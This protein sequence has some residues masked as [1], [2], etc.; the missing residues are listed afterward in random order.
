MSTGLAEHTLTPVILAAAVGEGGSA[1]MAT[2]A[3]AIAGGGILMAIARRFRIPGIVLLL[4]GGMA[5]G[6]EGLGIVDPDSLGGALNIL[7]SLAVGVILFEGGLTL[8][9]DGYRSTSVTIR[10]LLTIGVVT[11]WVATSV[12]IWAIFGYSPALA[13]LAAS[14]VIVTG[15]TVIQPILKRIRLRPTLHNIL[16][17]ESVLIDPVGVFLAVLAFEW[18]VGGAGDQAILNFLLRIAGGG[19]IGL[20]GGEI[21]YRILKHRLLPDDVINGFALGWAVLIF[22]VT[23]MLINAG[24]L[25]S[26]IVAGLI[27]GYRQPPA[28]KSVV[29]FKTTLTDLLIG[30]V[31][32]LLTAR[33]EFAQFSEF[34]TKGLILLAVIIFAVRPLAVILSTLGSNLSIRERAF[35]SWV[36]PRG[37]VAASMA[38]LFT[39]TLEERGMFA[40]PQFIETFVYSVIVSTVVLQGFTAGPLAWL[41]RLQEKHPAGWLI[42]GA[43]TTA[44]AVAQ[45]LREVRKVPVVLV[46]GNRKAVT[47]AQADGHTAI[48]ADARD[49]VSLSDRPELQG[50]GHL[51]AFTDN[52][53]LNELLCRKWEEPFGRANVYRWAS[54]ITSDTTATGTVLWSWMPKPSM[55]SSELTLGEAALV[56]LEGPRLK[57]PGNLAALLTANTKELLLDPGP[58]S[59]L[60]SDKPAPATLYLQREADYLLNALHAGLVLRLQ[61]ENKSAL[62]LALAESIATADS[63]VAA[64]QLFKQVIER[65]EAAPSSL[66]HGVALPH[67]HVPGITTPTCAIA[68]IPKGIQLYPDEPE[69]VR[70]VF[71]LVSPPERPEL[72]LAIL[73]EIARL[74]ADPQLRDQLIHCDDL[75]EVLVL[76]R[77]HRRQHTPFADARVQ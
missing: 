74:C 56:Q 65:E 1:I 4:A 49:A 32:I 3:F 47:D 14:L 53:D 59:A 25:L 19:L 44:T 22:A 37:V 63:R 8:N 70:L 5:L 57:N 39:L 18:L 52:E 2:L 48:L 46:D 60:K 54:H 75:Q 11:T 10:R 20:I 67:A 62:L 43:H 50:V 35:L 13:V 33:L 71:L 23:E 61:P 7:V 12:A 26:V 16:H 76:I 30:F 68:L 72:H 29:E 6:P 15:P 69:P 31:F 40:N 38:S 58:D 41:M 66:G 27:I 36:A 17:W 24:G 28:L 77:R 45:F 42:V 73:G 55:I 51:L 34:G 9:I 64:E 21:A